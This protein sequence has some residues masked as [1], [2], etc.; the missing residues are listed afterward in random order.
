[1][2]ID[3][4]KQELSALDA[5]TQRQVM[6]FLVSLQDARDDACRRQ[7]AEKMGR[8]AVEIAALEEL[9]RLLQ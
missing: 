9:H 1:V 5:D 3:L 6:V 2:S 4:L 8:P 7:L